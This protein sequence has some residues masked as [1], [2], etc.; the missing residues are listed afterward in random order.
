LNALYFRNEHAEQL[1]YVKYA[2][3]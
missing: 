1:W 2:C 3:R